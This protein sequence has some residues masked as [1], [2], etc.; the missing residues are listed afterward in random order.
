MH[1]NPGSLSSRGF[2]CLIGSFVQFAVKGNNG[3]PLT[4]IYKCFYL[5]IVKFRQTL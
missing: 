3:D 5:T 4:I 1:L 2:M